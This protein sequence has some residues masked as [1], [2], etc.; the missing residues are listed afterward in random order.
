M[1]VCVCVCVW[2][3]S[4]PQEQ[5]VILVQ[6]LSRVQRCWIPNFHSPRQVAIPRLK[7]TVCP[8]SLYKAE[9]RIIR[10][11]PSFKVIELCEMQT[12]LFRNWI[13]FVGSISY[14]DNHY[15]TSASPHTHIYIYIYIYKIDKNATV[16]N[17]VY[18][19][20]L[21]LSY[22]T[23]HCCCLLFLFFALFSI[24]VAVFWTIRVIPFFE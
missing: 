15:T 12:A 2:I 23:D 17:Q 21:L 22:I 9:G 3:P 5:E 4:H 24:S 6:F 13:Q 20:V 7:G 1:C 11:I 19:S 18:V 14:D 16:I 10:F 8:Y